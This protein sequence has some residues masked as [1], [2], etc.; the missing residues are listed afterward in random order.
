MV[1]G[2]CVPLQASLF[3]HQ[4]SIPP[5]VFSVP[6]ASLV[7]KDGLV[8]V[9]ETGGATTPSGAPDPAGSPAAA[10]IGALRRRPPVEPLN[11][12]SP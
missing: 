7:E 1:W 2:P 8:Q 3:T 5:S 10:T 9:P 6:W 12:A 4:F 11:I